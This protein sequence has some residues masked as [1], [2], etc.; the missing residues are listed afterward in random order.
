MFLNVDD[1]WE[2]SRRLTAALRDAIELAMDDGD[3]ELCSV[4]IGAVF[5]AV[6]DGMLQAFTSYCTRQVAYSSAVT[7]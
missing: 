2:A 3:E 7:S 1:L 6:E 4:A 5:L